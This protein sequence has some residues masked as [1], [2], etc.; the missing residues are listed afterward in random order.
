MQAK[1][2]TGANLILGGATVTI[3]KQSGT[4]TIGSVTDNSDGTYTA[5]V[6]AP[7]TTG[8]GVFV[9][10]LG[11]AAVRWWVSLTAD[12]V[13]SLHEPHRKDHRVVAD[14]EEE[15]LTASLTP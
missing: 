11:A 10:T 4:G 7:A 9:A 2:A 15:D 1:D 6:T 13:D 5:T 12:G 3:T 14:W 8:S